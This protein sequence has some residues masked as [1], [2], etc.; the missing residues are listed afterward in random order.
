MSVVVRL[1][2]FEGP[3]DLLLHLI[4][5]AKV[6]IRDIFVSQITEQFLQTVRAS[7]VLDM[8]VG[9]DFIAMAALLIELKSRAL[10][11]A[12]PREEGEEES[13]EDALIRRLAEYKRFKDACEELKLLEQ[14]AAATRYKLAEDRPPA[15]ADDALSLGDITLEQLTAAFAAL[16]ARVPAE[17]TEPPTHSIARETITLAAGIQRIAARVRKGAVRFCELFSANPSREEIVTLFLALLELLRT[18][19]VRVMQDDTFGDIV[20]CGAGRGSVG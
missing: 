16:L 7:G 18:A 14:T 12:P 2:D 1:T 19:R 13:P 20:I 4:S 15:F 11:P 8:E 9:S 10:L 6:Q 5:R 3:L 17:E